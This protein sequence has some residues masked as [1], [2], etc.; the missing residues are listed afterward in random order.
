MLALEDKPS[1]FYVVGYLALH[2][3]LI[4]VTTSPSAGESLAATRQG[5]TLGTISG[6]GNLEWGSVQVLSIPEVCRPVTA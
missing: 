5:G 2:G 6:F 1:H 3:D 4:N